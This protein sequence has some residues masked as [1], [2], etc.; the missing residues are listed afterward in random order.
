MSINRRNF[1]TAAGRLTLGG[2]AGMQIATTRA[3]EAS[4]GAG[5]P[6][7]IIHMVSD[8]MSSGTFTCADAL[9]QLKRGRPTVW[10]GLYSNPKARFG[11]MDM[12]SLNSLVTDSSAASSSWGSG[13]RIR[14]GVV[15]MLPDGTALTPIYSL[16][17]DAG[18]KRGLVTTTEITHATP[19]GFAANDNSRGS[20]EAIAEQYLERRVDLLLGGGAN[21]LDPSKRK[22]K[23]DL[24]AEFAQAGYT[25]MRRRGELADAQRGKPWLGIFSKSHIPFTVDWEN[26][27]DLQAVVPPLAEMT[28][29]ALRSLELS[30]HFI[31]Q[32]E[33]GRVDHG[34]HANDAAAA[35]NDQIAFDEA[36]E[37][38]L[39]FQEE[40]PDTL[41]VITTDHGTA[42]PALNG[43]GSSYSGSSQAFAHLLNT[44][45]SFEV[46]SSRL[47]KQPGVDKIREIITAATGYEVP[48]AKAEQLARVL[49][50]KGEAM[51]DSMN[52]TSAQLGQLM[53]NHTGVGFTSGNHT[54]DY[55]PILAIGPGAGRFGGFIKN[56]DIFHHYTE[57]AGIKFKNPEMPLEARIEPTPELGKHWLEAT[58]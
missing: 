7:H 23:R 16:F 29:H 37:V 43:M 53:A 40:V 57:L 55:V 39:K 20:A 41:I 44:K 17:A 12:H 22:D 38:C 9:S 33:G 21:H 14:N 15:N 10:R 6:R 2:A 24:F 56:T 8:G 25:V 48:A 49:D 45:A 4:G 58:V 50:G 13:S 3:G 5:I 1:F 34:A 30:R 54:A 52:S 26:T 18:W 19:A 46:L 47:G 28:R 27:P 51:F 35:F 32:V 31:L 42:N 11:Y 36:L